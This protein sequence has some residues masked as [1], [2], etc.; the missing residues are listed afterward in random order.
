MNCAK[1][2][3]ILFVPNLIWVAQADLKISSMWH[4]PLTSRHQNQIR[5]LLSSSECFYKIW[6]KSLKGFLRYC[7][8]ETGTDGRSKNLI[9]QCSQCRGITTWKESSCTYRVS[10]DTSGIC[11]N[12]RMFQCFHST[13]PAL[14]DLAEPSHTVTCDTCDTCNTVGEEDRDGR[15]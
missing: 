3:Q 14:W 12:P 1:S 11:G 6:K 5:S 10:L 13:A 8:H 15:G 9:P 7:V 2:N 4:W